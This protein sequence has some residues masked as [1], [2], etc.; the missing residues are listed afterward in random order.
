MRGESVTQS[1][2]QVSLSQVAVELLLMDGEKQENARA[3]R[4]LRQEIADR[5]ERLKKLVARQEQI[6]QAHFLA[7]QMSLPGLTYEKPKA[8]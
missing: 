1:S 3:I 5:Q 6:E 4:R 2:T 8:H 7:K